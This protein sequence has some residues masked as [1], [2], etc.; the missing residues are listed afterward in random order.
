M[1]MEQ[2]RDPALQRAIEAIGGIRA[3]ADALGLS[4]QSVW[5]WGKCPLHRVAQ[6]SDLSGVPRWELAP[7]HWERPDESEAK[8]EEF[9]DA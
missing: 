3:T 7:D 2:T 6:I 5:G 9:K 1:T 4:F 8:L